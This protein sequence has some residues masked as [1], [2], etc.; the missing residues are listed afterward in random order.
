MKLVFFIAHIPIATLRLQLQQSFTI[1]AP[2]FILFTAYS[3]L[4][5]KYIF[6]KL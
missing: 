3:I 5:G 4:N 6:Y 1:L 2:A